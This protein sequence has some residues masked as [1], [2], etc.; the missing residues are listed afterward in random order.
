MPKK[1]KK[2]TII[3]SDYLYDLTNAISA[4]FAVNDFFKNK[5]VIIYDYV[6]D[7]KMMVNIR[8]KNDYSIHF[9]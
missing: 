6:T 3:S 1:N 4:A 2:D 9:D 5:N 8:D 7:H